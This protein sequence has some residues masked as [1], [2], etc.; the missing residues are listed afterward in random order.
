[1]RSTVSL[2]LL[3]MTRDKSLGLDANAVSRL[4]AK[5]TLAY[6]FGKIFGGLGADSLGGRSSLAA[7]LATMGACFASL[8][9]ANGPGAGMT[10]AYA[11]LRFVHAAAW[12]ATTLVIRGWFSNNGQSLALSLG[13]AA[14]RGGAWLGSLLGG[15]VLARSRSWRGL[16]AASATMCSLFAAVSALGLSERPQQA[17]QDS[18]NGAGPPVAASAGKPRVSALEALKLGA[19]TPKLL[20]LLASNAMIT[21]TFDLGTLLPQF[22]SDEYS[23]DDSSIGSIAGIFPLAA[24]PSIIVSSVALSRLG[25]RGKALFLVAM[26]AAAVA[27]FLVLARRPA[28]AAVVPAIATI[29]AGIAPALYCIPPDWILRWGGPYAGLFSGLSDVPGNVLTML[30]YMLVPRLLQKGGWPRVMRLYALQVAIGAG[31]IASF[32]VLEAARPT[33]SSPFV[34]E[35]LTS[36]KPS[37]AEG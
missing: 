7:M 29:M 34:Q 4:N 5:G 1:V 14:S 36:G 37:S 19:R 32:Q 15:L 8:A 27:G 21:A 31:C 2:A 22:L 12:P 35:E 26:E 17:L 9:R 30:I 11:L 33:R 13:A 20:L 23:L 16:L 28:R 10:L 3:D 25:D 6:A 18:A 24:P